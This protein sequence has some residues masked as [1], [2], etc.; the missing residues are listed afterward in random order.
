MSLPSSGTGVSV[1]G[2]PLAA[3]TTARLMEVNGRD[4]GTPRCVGMEVSSV[5]TVVDAIPR[6]KIGKVDRPALV[7]MVSESRRSS[8]HGRP[9]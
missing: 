9:R 6:P 4:S 7:T 1:T 2:L 8:E 5:A 3:D